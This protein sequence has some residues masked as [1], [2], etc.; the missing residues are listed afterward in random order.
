M[1]KR[2]KIIILIA[3]F[4]FFHSQ[5]QNL[6]GLWQVTDYKLK[7]R[8]KDKDKLAFVMAG[9]KSTSFSFVD[10]KTLFISAQM[11]SRP[12]LYD[13]KFVDGKKT[14]IEAVEQNPLFADSPSRW[15]LKILKLDNN[16][17]HL[18]DLDKDKKGNIWVLTK[19]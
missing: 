6:Q 4:G 10:D 13:W 18:E 14:I 16:S 8:I 7:K 12:T 15:R 11:L 3:L 19:Q 17:L 1:M 9:A 5:A 2:T